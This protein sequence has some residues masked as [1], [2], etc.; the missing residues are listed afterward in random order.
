[1]I[2]QQLVWPKSATR[3]RD[4]SDALFYA[5][6]PYLA[7]ERA[8]VG[9]YRHDAGGEEEHRRFAAAFSA[10]RGTVLV[11]GYDS[12]LYVELY[13]GWHRAARAV[14]RPTSNQRG[15]TGASAVEVIWSNRPLAAQFD[16]FTQ[17]G[18]SSAI[19]VD[20]RVLEG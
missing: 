7:S 13:D 5:D 11:S 15:R 19:P 16:L 17:L 1:V 8:G 20:L 2:N 9:D 10:I 4:A 18:H 14:T 3:R 6:P 12:P